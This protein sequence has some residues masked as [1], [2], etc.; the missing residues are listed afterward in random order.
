MQ[1]DLNE[2]IL[3][4]LAG[5]HATS[6]GLKAYSTWWANQGLETCRQ[7]LGGHGYSAYSGF[8]EMLGDFAVMTTWEGDNTVLSQQLARYMIK[9]LR[10]GIKKKKLTGFE[11]YVANSGRILS[12]FF[13]GEEFQIEELLKAHEYVA[14]KLLVETEKRL[15][16]LRIQH[17]SKTKAWQE[18]TI[19]LVTTAKAHC[20]YFINHCFV[21]AVKEAPEPLK[22]ILSHVCLL[23][24]LVSIQ[25]N[26]ATL[27]RESYLKS[28]HVDL[29]QN[30]IR[31]LYRITREQA[32]SLVDSFNIPDVVLNSPLGRYDGDI[33]ESYFKVVKEAPNAIGIPSYHYELIRQIHHR[34]V[35]N[36]I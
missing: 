2:E 7:C 20:N 22:G 28:F 24:S 18:C 5:V 16:Y 32:V 4:S 14:V 25:Q 19:D 33:Y 3:S 6:A 35:E 34:P 11:S 17:S 9:Q 1:A 23:H 10:R 31:E 15:H 21:E 26:L 12:S 13:T 8:S 30:K 27:L 29:I 36:N